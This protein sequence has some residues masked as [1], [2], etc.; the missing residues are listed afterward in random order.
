MRRPGCSP[1]ASLWTADPPH[2]SGSSARTV[3]RTHLRS[4]R[5]PSGCQCCACPPFL[6]PPNSPSLGRRPHTH[7]QPLPARPSPQ[8]APGRVRQDGVSCRGAW[9]SHFLGTDNAGIFPG[10]TGR[11][12]FLQRS[13]TRY[14]VHLKT[15]F[16]VFLLMSY[17]NSSHVP[18]TGALC[19]TDLS[20]TMFVFPG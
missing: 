7:E 16:F 11:G 12:V 8:Q 15:G 2:A 14:S 3:R 10:L 20:I 17:K 5:R 19:A 18:E 6:V 13:V 4:P 9:G 1:P